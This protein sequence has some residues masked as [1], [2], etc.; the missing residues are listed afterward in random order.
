MANEI[1]SMSL[2]VEVFDN[3]GNF[4]GEWDYE[5]SRESL[6]QWEEADT[7]D[8][9]EGLSLVRYLLISRLREHSPITW[10]LL[11]N[12]TC[13]TEFVD[14]GVSQDLVAEIPR[15]HIV[16]IAVQRMYECLSDLVFSENIRIYH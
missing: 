5:V 2:V 11:T 7:E 8:P 10:Q 14:N 9:Q 15:L 6:A 4:E 13:I 16:N 1:E 12:N 3:A